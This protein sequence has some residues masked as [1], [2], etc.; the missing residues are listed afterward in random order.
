MSRVV[1]YVDGFNLYFGLKSA[2]LKRLYWLDLVALAEKMLLPNQTLEH[3]HYFTARIRQNPTNAA[4]VARQSDYLDALATLPRLSCH[5]GHFLAKPATCRSC[6]A[7]WLTYEEKMSDVNLAVQLLLDAVDNRFDT[8]IIISGDSDLI[9]PIRHVRA[10][11]PN[12]NVLIAFPPKR[13]S[14]DLQRVASATFAIGENKLRQSQLSDPVV[15]ASGITI[16][17][18]ATWR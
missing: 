2:R 6:G 1:V 3:V 9:T 11:F 12:K 14:V 13:H 18:P 15:T 16:G 7:N 10:R 5:E 17:R 8:A 4:S